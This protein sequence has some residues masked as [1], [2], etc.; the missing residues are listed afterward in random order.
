MYSLNDNFISRDIGPEITSSPVYNSIIFQAEWRLHARPFELLCDIAREI[1]ENEGTKI[2]LKLLD[3]K[4]EELSA[5][6]VLDEIENISQFYKEV[7]YRAMRPLLQE[8]PGGGIIITHSHCFRFDFTSLDG[9]PITPRA[10]VINVLDSFF[11]DNVKRQDGTKI[12]VSFPKGIPSGMMYLHPDDMSEIL[13]LLGY[14][15]FPARETEPA[16][17]SLLSGVSDVGSVPLK[18]KPHRTYESMVLRH[19]PARKKNKNSSSSSSVVEQDGGKRSIRQS[20]PL[21]EMARWKIKECK[22]GNY[23]ALY[24]DW[25]KQIFEYQEFIKEAAAT[26][27]AINEPLS[28]DENPQEFVDYL[29][30]IKAA[31]KARIDM[32]DH[33]QV[34]LSK[35]GKRQTKLIEKQ[36]NKADIET[37]I[38]NLNALIKPPSDWFIP[39][40]EGKRKED[41]KLLFRDQKAPAI[42]TWGCSTQCDHCDGATTIRVSPFPWIWLEQL[43]FILRKS[44]VRFNFVQLFRGDYFRDYYDFVYDK[45]SS[46]I[47]E[48]SPVGEVYTSGFERGSV[49]ERSFLK[50]LEKGSATSLCLSI[51]PSAWMRRLGIEKYAE[52]IAHILELAQKNRLPSKYKV[53]LFRRINDPTNLCQDIVEILKSKKMDYPIKFR[54]GSIE[55]CGRFWQLG[56]KGL[57]YPSGRIDA[58]DK[59]LN[60]DI[61]ESVKYFI[62]PDGQAIRGIKP[63]EGIMLRRYETVEGLGP[64]AKDP[65]EC[66]NCALECAGLENRCPGRKEVFKHWWRLSGY[67]GFVSIQSSSSLK[68]LNGIISSSSPVGHNVNIQDLIPSTPGNIDYPFEII[69]GKI[70]DKKTGVETAKIEIVYYGRL[71]KSRYTLL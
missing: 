34:P 45:D 16:G 19:R 43:E 64:I 37:Q 29:S 21:E 25:S 50:A 24:L 28:H 48:L 55:N 71:H 7:V 57:F 17:K 68:A 12:E 40:F 58:A 66:F 56:E 53:F 9:R 6:G 69:V 52:N 47:L 65:I 31:I 59:L 4:G 10:E 60:E 36:H 30:F 38:A 61:D 70:I 41:Y 20:L 23:S 11:A 46:N 2:Y 27:A 26:N 33:Y 22:R 49:A 14:R 44:S 5:F 18:Q 15:D 3:G 39:L 32:I 62:L 35:M 8:I 13:V 67:G 54:N 63:K 1:K 51:A 42:A